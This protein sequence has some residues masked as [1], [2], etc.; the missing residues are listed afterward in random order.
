MKIR[1]DNGRASHGP[2][3][4]ISLVEVLIAVTILASLLGSIALV[5]LSAKGAFSR[6]S[7]RSAV[8]LRSGIA[9]GAVLTELRM[10]RFES[11]IPPMPP[12]AGSPQIGYMLV[13]DWD[14]ND[15]VE[16]ERRILRWEI[17]AGEAAD[18]ADNDGDGLVDEGQLVLIEDFGLATQSRR[19]LARGVAELQEGELP[20]GID[21]NGN[22]L[23]DE[24]GFVVEL[25][26]ATLDVT[27]TL[28]D[29]TMGGEEII[30]RTVRSS[31]LLRN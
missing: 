16:S 10:A 5:S 30:A 6:G 17:E 1:I 20:N 26:G 22:G 8:E 9:M 29:S 3:R 23:I 28:L 24:P 12:G 7:T 14:G 18:N 11:L 15:V 19:L 13:L 25:R 31:T 21:D 2:T 4:G 27:L